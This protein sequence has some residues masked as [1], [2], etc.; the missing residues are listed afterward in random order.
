MKKATPKTTRATVSTQSP[1][2]AKSLA[3]TRLYLAGMSFPFLY[4]ELFLEV[5]LKQCPDQRKKPQQ[6]RW[7]VATQRKFYGF[8][9]DAD[10]L[11]EAENRIAVIGA[12]RQH[13]HLGGKPS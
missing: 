13:G 5:K 8:L 11:S 12:L 10:S 2:V 9:R 7:Q 3:H 6:T 4:S 1:F